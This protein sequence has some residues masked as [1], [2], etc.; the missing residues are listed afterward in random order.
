MRIGCV[1]VGGARRW[2][3]LSDEGAAPLPATTIEQL[4]AWVDAGGVSDGAVCAEAVL[5][6]DPPLRP[7]KVVGVGLN[8]RD[9]AAEVGA[10]LSDSPLLFAKPVTSV[11]GP[12]A[13][14]LVDVRVTAFPDWEVE[15]AVVVGRRMRAVPVEQALAHVLGYTVA[16]DVTARDLQEADGQWFRAKSI[17]TFCPLGPWIVTPDEVGDPQAL[18]LE[19]RVNGELVQ[20]STTAEMHASVAELLSFCSRHFTL[21]SG[22]VLLTGTPPGVGISMTP[23]RPLRAGDVVEVEVE[24]IGTLVNPVEQVERG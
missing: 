1:R 9:H 2:A 17:D 11:V 8:Y 18:R 24:R 16:N 10:A 4:V 14:I 23:P 20:Q 19:A 15:L 3:C 7:G 6:T 12:N 21:E 22:D 5:G 13:P